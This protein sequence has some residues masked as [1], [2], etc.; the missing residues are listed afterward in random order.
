MSRPA[1]RPPPLPSSQFTWQPRQDDTFAGRGGIFAPVQDDTFVGKKKAPNP[2]QSLGVRFQDDDT[3]NLDFTTELRA[4]LRNVA[5]R[6]RKTGRT[7][8]MGGSAQVG[9]LEDEGMLDPLWEAEV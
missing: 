1:I 6:R 4:S 7:S 5:P 8:V 3:E 9:I 2:R